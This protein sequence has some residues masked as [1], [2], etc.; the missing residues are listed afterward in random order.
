[1]AAGLLKYLAEQT[2]RATEAKSA[3]IA[4]WQ[5]DHLAEY[6]V[7]VMDEISIDTRDDFPKPVTQELVDWAGIIIP[8]EQNYAED[9]VEYFP[10]AEDKIR[11]IRIAIKDSVG[12]SISVY[13]QCRDDLRREVDFFLRRE[14]GS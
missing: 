10:I 2:G 14:L 7:K 8:L 3:G 11:N 5:G 12:K 4:A 13:R 6:A 9:L 1:M